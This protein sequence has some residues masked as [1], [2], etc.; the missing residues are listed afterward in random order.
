MI[1]RSSKFLLLFLAATLLGTAVF[2]AVAVWQLSRGPVSLGFLTP[3]VEDSLSGGP[4][5]VQVRLHDTVLT[6]AGLERTLDV[7]AVGLEILASDGEVGAS[8]PEWSV[9]F[10]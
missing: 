10:S 8:V 5:G 9:Q 3:F 6:W 7:R 2:A 1:V 4:D